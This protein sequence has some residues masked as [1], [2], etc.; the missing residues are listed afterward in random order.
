MKY[1]TLVLALV[2]STAISAHEHT[3]VT[4]SSQQVVHPV[5]SILPYNISDDGVEQPVCWGIDT[6]WRW[7]WWPLR[8]TNHMRECVSLGRVTIDP[9]LENVE[10]E[11][12][13]D[14]KKGL[15][16]QL[17]WLKKSGVKDL[18]LLS[19]NTSGKAW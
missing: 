19:G 5:G 10:A 2:L 18:Y 9:R 3:F 11:L 8:A 4:T 6:A 12:S 16:E 7:D 17:G 15:D 1:F 14:Q 13:T